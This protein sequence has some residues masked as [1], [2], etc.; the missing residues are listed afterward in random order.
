[1]FGSPTPRE[2]PQQKRK[3]EPVSY[4]VPSRKGVE[5]GRKAAGMGISAESVKVALGAQAERSDAQR[6][7]TAMRQAGFEGDYRSTLESNARKILFASETRDPASQN[8]GN[9][10][11]SPTPGEVKATAFDMA[12]RKVD[13]IEEPKLRAIAKTVVEQDF[14]IDRSGM[15][16]VKGQPKAEKPRE[17]LMGDPSE[18]TEAEIRRLGALARERRPGDIALEGI[19]DA[20]LRKDIELLAKLQEEGDRR[21]YDAAEK[22][23]Q[24]RLSA[25][26]VQK[27]KQSVGGYDR[28]ATADIGGKSLE[29]SGRKGRFE[30]DD[31][32]QMAGSVTEGTTSIPGAS[33]QDQPKVVKDALDVIVQDEKERNKFLSRYSQADQRAIKKKFDKIKDDPSSEAGQLAR[34]D[35]LRMVAKALSIEGQ[36]KAKEIAGVPA[37]RGSSATRAI[38]NEALIRS[39]IQETAE[40]EVTAERRMSTRKAMQAIDGVRV[41]YAPTRAGSKQ[42]TS[43][44]SDIMDAFRNY[45]Q[46]AS[47]LRAI[48]GRVRNAVGQSA[49]GNMEPVNQLRKA[50]DSMERQP[51]STEAQ[52]I[53]S[54]QGDMSQLEAIMTG[55]GTRIRGGPSRRAAQAGIPGVPE[56]SPARAQEYQ[57][58]KNFRIEQF[59]R[60]LDARLVPTPYKPPPPETGTRRKKPSGTLPTVSNLES[61]ID[62]YLSDI[63]AEAGGAGDYKT[64]DEFMRARAAARKGAMVSPEAYRRAEN[65][66]VS[67]LK[68]LGKANAAEMRKLQ[69]KKLPRVVRDANQ[70]EA[71]RKRLAEVRSEIRKGR[72]SLDSMDAAERRLGARYKTEMRARQGSPDAPGENRPVAARITLRNYIR[73]LEELERVIASRIGERGEALGKALRGKKIGSRAAAALEREVERGENVGVRP[74]GTRKPKPAAKKAAPKPGTPTLPEMFAPRRGV[75]LADLREVTGGEFVGGVRE[76]PGRPM[77]EARKR[78]KAK[79]GR[80]RTRRSEGLPDLARIRGD[81]Q[82]QEIIE[83]LPR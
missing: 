78:L 70:L 9:K 42:M 28:Q 18:M 49:A 17:F 30:G 16:L 35:L 24:Q 55:I 74:S 12:M 4:D 66:L 39:P 34:G 59:Q 82:L 11:W 83:G 33:A 36:M 14:G 72:A 60:E 38:P 47:I 51:V 56:T 2:A 20:V 64:A 77:T 31:R 10:D 1:M 37:S 81:R 21:K 80:V 63:R 45:T 15:T 27:G 62:R 22:R 3:A 52:R 7:A 41:G 48:R 53:A 61:A 32:P 75:T 65:L 57:G 26:L 6:I 73:E 5:S 40:A 76:E 54:R 79:K 8:F 67:R 69:D 46:D 50:L 44:V 43:D 19:S 58:G 68:A 13:R 23:F 71:V 25:Y 29:E